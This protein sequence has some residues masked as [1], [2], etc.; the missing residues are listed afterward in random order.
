MRPGLLFQELYTSDLAHDKKLF[1]HTQ[2]I[3]MKKLIFLL[4]FR[5]VEIFSTHDKIKG[6]TSFFL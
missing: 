3:C 6:L 1:G 5:R 4:N 2:N